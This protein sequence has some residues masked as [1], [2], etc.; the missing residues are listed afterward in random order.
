MTQRLKRS[1]ICLLPY[2]SGK[3][4]AFTI[5]DDT[6]MAT[7]ESIRPVYDHLLALGLKTTKTVWALE[8]GGPVESPADAGDTLERE[9]YA[10]YMLHLQRNGFEIALHNVSGQSSERLR[11]LEGLEAFRRV[12]GG[13]PRINVHHEKNRE[14]LHFAF[15]QQGG[16]RPPS[17]RTGALRRLHRW[18]NRG[19]QEAASS[20]GCSGEE[21]GSEYFW[22]D[23]CRSQFDYVRSNV[24]FQDLNT[25]KCN[26]FIPYSSPDTPCVKYWFDASNGQDAACFDSI[27]SERNVAM[28]KKEH[29]CAILYTH[30]GKGGFVNRT[31]G[32]FHL[33]GGVARHLRSIAGDANGWYVPVSVMLDRL[34][35]FQGVTALRLPGGVMLTNHNASDIE[36]LTLLASPGQTYCD[37]GALRLMTADEQGRLVLPRL[38][39]GQIIALVCREA[40]SSVRKWYEEAGHPWRLDIRTVARKL[41]K[42]LS[43]YA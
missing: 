41:R 20:Y 40:A 24:F 8:P 16:E 13:D 3:T 17:F 30:F 42:R 14:N 25:L 35:V 7:L 39:A 38:P 6:D 15:A 33:D 43:Q 10:G 18:I 4:F 1:E 36:C 37:V 28:L 2:P 21:T 22:G 12:M 29:G 5:I 26:P 34:L 23:I 31:N 27:L 11:I 32:A 19:R 9:D